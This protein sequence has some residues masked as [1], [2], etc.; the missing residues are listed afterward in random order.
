MYTSDKLLKLKGGDVMY[1]EIGKVI[2][3]LAGT[4][5]GVLVTKKK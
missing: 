3:A 4:L 2:G 5:I 1:A